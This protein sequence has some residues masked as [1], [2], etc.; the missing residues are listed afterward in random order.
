MSNSSYY[1][2]SLLTKYLVFDVDINNNMF[3][4]NDPHYG[5]NQRFIPNYLGENVYIFS[6]EYNNS[7]VMTAPSDS[8]EDKLRLS[9]WDRKMVNKFQQFK[10]I[11]N[12]DGYFKIQNV[13]SNF[14][15]E[16]QVI[17]E[18]WYP[19]FIIRV[20]EFR[21]ERQQLFYFEKAQN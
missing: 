19:S 9:F 2:K 15:L 21:N 3:I 4:I 7:L 5:S 12:Y 18:L 16:A 13:G 11:D 6:V 10:L 14:Y 20:N 1:I 17:E 8:S